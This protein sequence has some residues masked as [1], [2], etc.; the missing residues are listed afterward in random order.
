MWTPNDAGE[1]HIQNHYSRENSVNET[2]VRHITMR[3]TVF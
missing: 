1:V 3:R 2:R